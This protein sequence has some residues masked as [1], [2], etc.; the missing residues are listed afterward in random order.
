MADE[1][2]RGA[3]KVGQPLSL[4]IAG[5][6]MEV[7]PWLPASVAMLE[8]QALV[9]GPPVAEL[10]VAAPVVHNALLVPGRAP[11][12][13]LELR[14]VDYSRSPVLG[15]G[16]PGTT[17]LRLSVDLRSIEPLFNDVRTASHPEYWTVRT[18]AYE[19][20]WPPTFRLHMPAEPVTIRSR[21]LE[22]APPGPGE[23]PRLRCGS[24]S[25]PT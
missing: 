17:E 11:T 19:F 16:Q 10:S 4:V 7:E 23:R 6:G 25:W 5:Y 2:G 1:A 21:H 12:G 9:F 13:P 14:D 3:W 15:T 24:S 18:P 8:N 20:R 22:L